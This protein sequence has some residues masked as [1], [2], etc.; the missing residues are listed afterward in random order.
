MSVTRMNGVVEIDARQYGE[1]VGLEKR[2]QRLQRI[3][4]NNH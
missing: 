4:Q 3:K 1:Y 2:N